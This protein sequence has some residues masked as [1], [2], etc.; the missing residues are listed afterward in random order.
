MSW[1]CT[2]SKNQRKDVDQRRAT[3]PSEDQTEFL[4]DNCT[5]TEE[6]GERRRGFGIRSPFIEPLQEANKITLSPAS[7]QQ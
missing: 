7:G 3:E 1:F 5:D 6:S 2:Y 4:L